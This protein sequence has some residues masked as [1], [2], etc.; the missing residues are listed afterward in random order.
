VR[1]LV[2]T[3]VFLEVLLA[4][5]RAT[6]ARKF[7]ASSPAHELFATDYTVH[8][9]GLLLFRRKQPDIFRQFVDDIFFKSGAAMVSLKPAELEAVIEAASA[10]GLDFDDAYQY[11]TAASHGLSIVSFDAHFDR[12]PK[13]RMLPSQVS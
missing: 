6:E 7:L 8:S 13:G 3:N 2:D 11:A 4:Q 1:L 5:A 10:F 9:V 12:T